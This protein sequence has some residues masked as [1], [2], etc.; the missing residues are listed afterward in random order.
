MAA[1]KTHM[2]DATKAPAE[3]EASMEGNWDRYLAPG[4][5]ERDEHLAIRVLAENG[6]VLRGD[7][8][9]A[10]TLLRQSGVVDDQECIAPTDE[11]VGFPRE[12]RLRAPH[13][14]PA[15][16]KW[17]RAS[18]LGSPARSAMGWTLLRFPGPI[19]PA[20]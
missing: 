15:A 13:P 1:A 12:C 10:G 17:C 11:P 4:Q 2:P 6:G 8:G 7:F 19:S 20:T 18:W 9:R 16:M 14:T 5:G 3:R